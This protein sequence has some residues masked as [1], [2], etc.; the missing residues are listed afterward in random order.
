MRRYIGVSQ[1]EML[2]PLLACLVLVVVYV[3][4]VPYFRPLYLRY[5]DPDY[6]YLGNGLALNYLVPVGHVDHPGTPVQV[7]SA[8][9]IAL[10]YYLFP[11]SGAVMYK[12]VLSHPESYLAFINGLIF[13]VIF[14]GYFI[15]SMRMRKVGIPWLWVLLPFAFVLNPLVLKYLFRVNA[16]VFLI[17]S[18]YLFGSELLIQHSK[19]NRSRWDVVL[20]AFFAALM[21]VTKISTLPFTLMTFLV[22]KGVRQRLLL[23]GLAILF[24]FVFFLPGW[25]HIDYFL[26]WFKGLLLKDG[27]Y[28]QGKSGFNI[29]K[30]WKW[31]LNAYRLTPVLFYSML[32][33]VALLP[34]ML[35]RHLRKFAYGLRISFLSMVYIYGPPIL[36]F[37]AVLKHFDTR[38]LVPLVLSLPFVYYLSVDFRSSVLPKLSKNLFLVLCLGTLILFGFGCTYFKEDYRFSESTHRLM[39]TKTRDKN[40]LVF[41][42]GFVRIIPVHGYKLMLNYT[43]LFKVNGA[44][45]F[46]QEQIKRI[47]DKGVYKVTK[48]SHFTSVFD[49][50]EMKYYYFVENQLWCHLC[51]N[52]RKVFRE[53]GPYTV[54]EIEPSKCGDMDK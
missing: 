47:E 28:G 19:K 39:E 24:F 9:G 25:P 20:L 38:Y 8:V 31:L 44:V 23:I 54:F 51:P 29:N 3:L 50:K 17:L 4:M 34:I 2:W 21:V 43:E 49:R 46:V 1:R 37:V 32:L 36:F 40:S 26:E 27:R 10:K 14:L 30:G 48:P 16:E 12:D 15:T 45:L 5:S 35:L 33:P 18:V 6:V 53:I 13:V 11:E 7:L 42:D 41:L 52:G 22:V